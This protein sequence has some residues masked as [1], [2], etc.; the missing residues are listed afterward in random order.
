MYRAIFDRQKCF[1]KNMEPFFLTLNRNE[2][3]QTPVFNSYDL[4]NALKVQV[5]KITSDG[6]TALALSGGID[7][8]ILARFMPK[9]SVAY[10]FKCVVP[11]MAVTDETSSAKSYAEECGL[12]HRIVEIYWKDFEDYAPLLMRHK[13]APIHSIEVQI[14]KA[15][16]QARA[17]GFDRLIFGEGADNGYG[18]LDKIMSKDWTIG[19]FIERFSYIM[20]YKVLREFNLILEPFLDNE[21]NGY[22]NLQ[23]FLCG[24]NREES[25]NNYINACTCA[26]IKLSTPYLC[27]R[28]A[29][30]IDYDRIRKGESKYLVREVFHQLY[31][32]F[33]IPIKTPMPRPMNEWMANWQGPTRPE[34]WPHCTDYMTGDQK[35]LVYILEKFLTMIEGK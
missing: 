6:K 4:E 2:N 18:G 10:T 13:G 21:E 34:F 35:W 12:E 23:N 26:D 24:F 17:D 28:L 5:E 29:T 19:D 7:S 16:L 3:E 25:L 32:C 27:T 20:P 30:S 8:A 11:G 9:G 1:D 14:Y 15:A 31:P 22:I 33:E